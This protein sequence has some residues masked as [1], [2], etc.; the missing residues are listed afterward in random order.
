MKPVHQMQLLFFFP[1]ALGALTLGLAGHPFVAQR[2]A[3]RFAALGL[4]ACLLSAASLWL[5]MAFA[6]PVDG[7]KQVP[8]LMGACATPLLVIGLIQYVISAR[9]T[10]A[11]RVI[12]ALAASAFAAFLSPVFLLLAACTIQADCL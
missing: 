10:Q 11:S 3:W 6:T 8:T 7:L 2:R 9:W 5:V 12:L 4:A 1:L